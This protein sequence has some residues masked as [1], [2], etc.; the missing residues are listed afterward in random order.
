MFV[1]EDEQSPLTETAN[2]G[3]VRPFR[4]TWRQLPKTVGYSPQ[5]GLWTHA[6]SVPVA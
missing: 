2:R 3:T 5:S 4:N 1:E 6:V